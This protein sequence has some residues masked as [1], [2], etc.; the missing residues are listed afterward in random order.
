MLIF[1]GSALKSLPSLNNLW[2]RAITN[3]KNWHPSCAYEK[4]PWSMDLVIQMTK[5][6]WLL[7][8]PPARFPFIIVCFYI[9]ACPLQAIQQS[10]SWFLNLV[11]KFRATNEH[12]ISYCSSHWHKTHR[13]S[14][15]EVLAIHFCLKR[16]KHSKTAARFGTW[17]IQWLTQH[18][19]CH[20]V[21]SLVQALPLSSFPLT[22]IQAR[23]INREILIMVPLCSYLCFHSE[24]LK[25]T[26]TQSWEPRYSALSLLTSGTG[27][28]IL[29][30]QIYW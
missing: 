11:V 7:L 21:L 1:I 25:G 22:L 29:T 4:V 8:P 18:C 15:H 27:N 20:S 28:R 26:N 30:T 12:E 24:I 13:T 10:N 6:I 9:I 17:N 5:R 3:M 19:G 14:L 2:E 23:N 16:T